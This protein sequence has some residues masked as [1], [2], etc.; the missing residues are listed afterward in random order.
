[1]PKESLKNKIT[2][3]AECVRLLKRQY[4]DAVTSL[5]HRSVY[6]LLVA[7]ILSAQCT[8]ERVNMVTPGLFKKYPTVKSFADADLK[9]L[10]QDIFT[11]GFLQLQGESDQNLGA[12][13]YRAARRQ[14]TK[15]AG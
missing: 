3:A 1:M 15:D 10:A 9:E 8:D 11:T 2:R 13:D 5:T 6:Q 12:A 7:T 14:S 4:P